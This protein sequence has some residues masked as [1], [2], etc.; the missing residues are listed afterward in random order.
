MRETVT[1]GVNSWATL[2]KCGNYCYSITRQWETMGKYMTWILAYPSTKDWAKDDATIR[3]CMDFA[4]RWGYGSVTLAYIF[5]RRVDNA[6]ELFVMTPAEAG[7]GPEADTEL[8]KACPPYS[9]F[10]GWDK[11]GAWFNRQAGVL[12]LLKDHG[13]RPY[14]MGETAG[15]YPV[16]PLKIKPDAQSFVFTGIKR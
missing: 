1:L 14:S 3:K 6:K 10:V 4:K 7:L 2:S 8:I 11:E 12:T 9:V 16:H 13:I 5:P 15:G